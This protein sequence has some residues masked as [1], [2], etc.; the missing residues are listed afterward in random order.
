[1]KKKDTYILLFL[2]LLILNSGIESN[3]FAFLY[4]LNYWFLGVYIFGLV[5]LIWYLDKQIFQ[6]IEK[7]VT[8]NIY[9]LKTLIPYYIVSF[10]V[11]AI[12]YV[13][14]FSLIFSLPAPGNTNV[15]FGISTTSVLFTSFLLTSYFFFSKVKNELAQ[16]PKQVIITK[17]VDSVQKFQLQRGTTSFQ[18]TINNISYFSLVNSI[19]YLVQV[20][21]TTFAIMDTLSQIKNQCTTQELFAAN[22]QFLITKKAVK[23]WKRTETRKLALQLHPKTSEEVTVS[24]NKAPEFIEW[25]KK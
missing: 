15:G 3:D 7:K 16:K 9:K 17:T 4:S 6:L 21:G 5:S 13:G 22:R 24:K 11:S 12:V 1:M 8:T 10:L 23:S 19:V 20:D 2:S 25:L 14:G 18:I